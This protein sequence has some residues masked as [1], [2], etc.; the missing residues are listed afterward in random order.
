M[1]YPKY[2]ITTHTYTIMT[3]TLIFPSVFSSLSLSLSH[4]H[5]IRLWK[6]SE[7]TFGNGNG[8]FFVVVTKYTKYEFKFYV[9]CNCVINVCIH[10]KIIILSFNI[11]YLPAAATSHTRMCALSGSNCTN[12]VDNTQV[13][14]FNLFY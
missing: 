4:S 11:T 5:C 2:R 14:D 8:N 1:P 12:V 7:T 10:V 3:R 13:N 9:V 6:L